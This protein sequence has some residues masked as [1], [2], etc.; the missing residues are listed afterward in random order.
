MRVIIV[1]GV[2]GGM[3]AATRMRRLDEHA[4]IIVFEQ[5]DHV[6]FANCGLPY[7][8]GGVISERESLLLQTPESLRARFD[9]DVRTGWSVG[10][11]DRDAQ[12]VSVRDVRSGA[13]Q[14]ERYDWLI[15]A[16]GAAARDE[17]V[18]TVD[19]PVVSTL[20]TIDDVDRLTDALAAVPTRPAPWSPAADS[21]DSKP[22]RTSCVGGSRSRLCSAALTL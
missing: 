6:S 7:Y 15:L 14:I 21:S 11:I 22:S 9:L 20:R 19:G 12:T 2:A 3:S 5:G 8:V 4:E 17:F 16:T 1:G 13:V 18:R 10:S